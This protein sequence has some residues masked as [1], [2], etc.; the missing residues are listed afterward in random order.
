MDFKTRTLQ[1]LRAHRG[2]LAQKTA[3]V[4]FDGFVDTIVTAVD[5]RAGQGDNFTPF[6]GIA[7]FGQRILGAAG[8][9]TN[10]EF[11]PRMDKLGGNGPIM[12]NALLA[13]GARVT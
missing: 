9:S 5:Q 1:E 8:K 11:Y 2:T 10:L 6:T 7:A 12:G 4:G 13:H 3:L